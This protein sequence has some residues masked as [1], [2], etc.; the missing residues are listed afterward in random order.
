ME[1]N[2]SAKP[3]YCHNLAKIKTILY[4][5]IT[6]NKLQCI[7]YASLHGKSVKAWHYMHNILLTTLT[8]LFSMFRGRTYVEMEEVQV[9]IIDTMCKGV[10]VPLYT[11]LTSGL[12][13][14]WWS[15]LCS[16]SCI[17]YAE[18]QT[19]KKD[20]VSVD[21]T[22]LTLPRIKPHYTSNSLTSYLN[23]PSYTRNE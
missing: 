20:G 5:V 21:V 17:Y 6:F 1:T 23:W 12:H 15:V 9:L 3:P 8:T 2:K 10:D 22:C 7:I 14:R 4:Y 16:S 18:G 13:E 19:D 11:F